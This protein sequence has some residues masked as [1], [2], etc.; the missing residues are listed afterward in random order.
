MLQ[1]RFER[2]NGQR[3]GVLYMAERASE[4][5]LRYIF[6]PEGTDE[7]TDLG[8]PYQSVGARG[9][10]NL[11]S[12]LLL[13]LFPPD[14]GF[15]TLT[16]DEDVK[17]M[18]E[19]K[20]LERVEEILSIAETAILKEINQIKS[21]RSVLAEAMKH[22]IITGNVA[23]WYTEDTLKLYSLRDYVVSRD[24]AGNLTEVILRETIDIDALPENIRQFVETKNIQGESNGIDQENPQVTLYTG[25]KLVD[26]KWEMWQEVE[27][28]EVPKTRRTVKRLPILVLRWTAT[29]YG[30]G[31]IE[32]HLGDL[33]TLESLTRA[34][35]E[36]ALMSAKTVFL[37]D[38]AGFTEKVKLANAQNGD[39]IDGRAEDV[40]TLQL[41]KF[42]DFR[43][44]YQQMVDLETR[45]NQVFL[46]FAPRNAERVTAEEIRR[47][48][49]QL[50]QILGGVYTLLTEELQRALI[51]LVF[52]KLMKEG[53]IPKMPKEDIN[54][55][56]TTGFEVLSKTAQLNKLMLMLQMIG[57][58]PDA[59]QYIN[60]EGYLKR[61]LNNLNINAKGLIKTQEEL[62]IEQQQLM[63]QQLQAQIGAQASQAAIQQ[64][65]QQSQV[66]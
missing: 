43:I 32:Q 66:E 44:A 16:L 11:M 48:T 47:L 26:G 30:R 2:L 61:V 65:Q 46:I 4:L 60:W 52:D 31:L 20:D 40:T 10:N 21:F 17:Q 6:P 3:H 49:E 57:G 50:E 5:T 56:I 35:K 54:V 39:I 7:N 19:P 41:N 42:P 59:L 15:F 22:L 13:T 9:V 38:P 34:T 23:L 55:T 51:E 28:I 58:I 33:E 45:L 62:M 24:K 64:A 29:K 18:L 12:K 37:I 1:E 36:G 53:K 8:T 27:D 63:A 25:A 14:G